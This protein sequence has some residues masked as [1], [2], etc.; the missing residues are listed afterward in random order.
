MNGYVQLRDE[1]GRQHRQDM[2]RFAVQTLAASNSV[3]HELLAELIESIDAAQTQ[4]RQWF[5]AAIEQVE[6][7]NA[8]GG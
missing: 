2:G 8:N 1:L 5:T 4:D 7:M 3:T 6:P